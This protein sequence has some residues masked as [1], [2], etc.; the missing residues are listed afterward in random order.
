MPKKPAGNKLVT[1]AKNSHVP[2]VAS[3]KVAGRKPSRPKNTKTATIN[4][5]IEPDTKAKA[6]KI[7]DKLGIGMSDAISMFLKQVI[8]NRG[9]PYELRVPNAA[10]RRA[11][12]ELKAGKNLK[13]YSSTKEMFADILK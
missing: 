8:F 12:R 1:R 11:F 3:S 10:T 4:V 9:I 6:E 2:N 7:F 13:T 5:R